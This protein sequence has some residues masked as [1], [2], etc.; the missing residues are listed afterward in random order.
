MRSYY[1]SCVLSLSITEAVEMGDDDRP[2]CSQVV[3]DEFQ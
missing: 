1:I 3:G 2:Q